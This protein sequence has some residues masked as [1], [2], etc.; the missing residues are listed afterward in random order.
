MLGE[1]QGTDAADVRRR[2]AVSAAADDSTP[3]PGDVDVDSAGEELDRRRRVVEIRERVPAFVRADRDDRGE[4]PRIALNGHVVRRGDQHRAAKVGAVGDLVK[5]ANELAFRRREAHVHD[6][7]SLLDCPAQAGEKNRAA[8][9][10]ALAEYA[11]AREAAIRSERAD[12][13]GTCRPM[14]REVAP[15]ILLHD[16][17]PVIADGDGDRFLDLADERMAG[18][19]PLSTM[20]TRTPSPREPPNA[21]SRVTFSGQLAGSLISP[22]ASAGRLHAGSSSAA[23]VCGSP[24]LSPP[25][26]GCLRAPRIGRV[27]CGYNVTGDELGL[28]HSRALRLGKEILCMT[29]PA[30]PCISRFG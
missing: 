10:E 28:A 5:G 15:G 11:H 21:H 4:P 29:V 2:E 27:W 7:I 23:V 22:A 17:L 16:R 1:D 25:S 8:A 18:L 19:D 24:M 30:I 6:G 12:D 14:P 9:Y 26:R 13:P 20:Q 3:E